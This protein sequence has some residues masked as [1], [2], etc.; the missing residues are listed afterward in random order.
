V[1]PPR[2]AGALAVLVL[3]V[4]GCARLSPVLRPAPWDDYPNSGPLAVRG[5]KRDAPGP[6]IVR[7]LRSEPSLAALFEGHGEPDAIE[8]LGGRYQPKDIALLYKRTGRRIVVESTSDGWVARAPEALPGA[9]RT[10][11]QARAPEAPPPG[12]PTTAQALE[13]PIDPMR[14]DCQ[15][16]CAAEAKYE[17]CP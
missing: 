13:C 4:A 8:V 12:P 5:A 7:A 1:S 15:A 6:R 10:T 2:W 11:R 16:L 3:V 17:W 14:A 9:R